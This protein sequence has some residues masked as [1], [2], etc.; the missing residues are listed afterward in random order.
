MNK[1][2]ELQGKNNNN[3]ATEKD[4]RVG[5]NVKRRVSLFS[6][7]V[8]VMILCWFRC[9]LKVP[10]P[11]SHLFQPPPNQCTPVDSKWTLSCFVL[12]LRTPISSSISCVRLSTASPLE[13]VTPPPPFH[14]QRELVL[15]QI[16]L[17]FSKHSTFGL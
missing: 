13:Q 17:F 8:V 15:H 3:P 1:I 11:S 6:F 10:V 12:Q 5:S 7:V 9:L 16:F 2:V 4:K 14:Q